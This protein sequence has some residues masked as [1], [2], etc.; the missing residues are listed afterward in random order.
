MIEDIV[1]YLNGMPSGWVKET[2]I[3]ILTASADEVTCEWEVTEKHHQG[4]GIVHGGVHCGVVETLA[5]IGAAVVAMPRRQRVADPSL[6]G[7]P[8]RSGKPGSGTSRNAW[9][10]RATCA[11]SVWTR[12]V[13][14]ARQEGEAPGRGKPRPYM[15][16]RPIT[17][18]VLAALAGGVVE[19][20][21]GPVALCFELARVVRRGTNYPTS[22][23][24]D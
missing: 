2:G 21:A 12:T 1:A 19:D 10:R 7:A 6:E 20:C 16:L 9:W 11:C 14:S 8:P 23:R 17:P 24:Q 15:P 13:R 4:F 22:S 18:G 5:S 3:T